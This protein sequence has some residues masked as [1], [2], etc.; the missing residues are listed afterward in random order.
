M[1]LTA[2]WMSNMITDVIKAYIPVILTYILAI[3]FDIKNL[4]GVWV[5]FLLFPLAIVPS[6]YCISFLFKSDTVA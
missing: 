2:Y 6:T 1:S 5:Q 4:N 3:I